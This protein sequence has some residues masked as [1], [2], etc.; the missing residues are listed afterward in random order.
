MKNTIGFAL[1][2]LAALVSQA[3]ADQSPDSTAM[4]ST[5]RS[6]D[7]LRGASA[8]SAAVLRIPSTLELDLTEDHL[9]DL[10]HEEFGDWMAVLPGFYPLDQAALGAP[11]R[12]LILGLDPSVAE[13]QFRG[14]RVEDHLLGGADLGWIPPEALT[15]VRYQPLAISS[16]GGRIEALLRSME[17]APPSSHIAMRDGYYGLGTVDFDLV[18]K[19][20]P[21]VILNGGGRVAT[22]GGRVLNSEGYG[23]NLRS[24]IAF[25]LN[26]E[27]SGWGG[28]MQGKQNSQ[29]PS[30]DGSYNRDRYEADLAMQ[31]RS[32]QTSLF[33]IQ[34]R[35]TYLGEGSDGW[36]EIG[37]MGRWQADVGAI[38][39]NTQA[40]LSAARW[41]LKGLSWAN[42][43]FGGAQT[44]WHWQPIKGFSGTANLGL[45]LSDD[46]APARHLG[47]AVRVAIK[48]PLAGFVG[49]SQYQVQSTR[50]ESAADFQ[51]GEHYLPYDPALL[52]NPDLP[53]LGNRSLKNEIYT[54]AMTGLELDSRRIH[55]AL[56]L[57]WRR[58]EDPILWQVENGALLQPYNGAAGESAG[59][60]GWLLCNPTDR[61]DLGATGSFLPHESGKESLFPETIAH[62]WAQFRQKLFKD[63]LE[64][65]FRLGGDYWGARQAPIPG[66]WDDW[67]EVLVVNGRISAYLLGAHLFW[68]IN[69]IF[70][71]DYMLY[72]GHGMMHKEEVW[73]VAWNFRN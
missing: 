17:A 39:T 36:D 35:E 32:F 19:I 14:R 72:P 30:A 48:D 44:E 57:F 33:G 3:R 47:I 4:D 20:A 34:R 56:G 37:W 58:I 24:E 22:Y 23:L 46:F 38:Q 50:F 63:E 62:A 16:A 73:G 29:V 52:Q 2:I 6:A 45:D 53:L 11:Y 60:L 15:R 54:T 71:Q 5:Q 61:L 1:L 13:L 66:G 41:R 27:I 69:N 59:A 31:Y 8:D 10:D 70:S 9:S 12:G 65:R 7:E 25:R 55:G 21:A 67:G 49:L 42:T 64:L 68:G 28:L 18:Q 43:T 26:S 40:R 51:P